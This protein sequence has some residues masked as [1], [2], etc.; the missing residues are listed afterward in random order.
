MHMPLHEKEFFATEYVFVRKGTKFEKQL[1]KE[2]SKWN[3]RYLRKAGRRKNRTLCILKALFIIYAVIYLIVVWGVKDRIFQVR[4]EN[5]VILEKPVSEQSE[6][7]F[8]DTINKI[9]LRL[10]SGE[11]VLYH[12]R[13]R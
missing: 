6:G 8:T 4:Q 1:K 9:I 3:M 7:S 12:E 13:T 2:R 5:M 11:V 10:K